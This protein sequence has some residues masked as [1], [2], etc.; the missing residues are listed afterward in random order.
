MCDCG[1][2]AGNI[3]SLL[4]TIGTF[5]L[6]AF[7][8]VQSKQTKAQIG[9]SNRQASSG[10]ISATAAIESA[11]TAVDVHS[12][13]IRA[14]I[15]Q[16]AP[17]V[18]AFF[19]RP[20]GPLVD[21]QRSGMPQ[22]N[23]LRLLD[24]ESI[25]RS[26]SKIGQQYAFPADR[27]T[28]IWYRGVGAVVNEGSTSA[29]VR[30]TGESKFIEGTSPLDG[31]ALSMPYVAG[32]GIVAEAILPPGSS[33]LF[34]WAAGHSAQ[35]WVSAV[36]NPEPPSP[37]GAIWQTIV[38]FDA[39]RA[40]IVDTIEAVYTP[41]PLAESPGRQGL[42]QLQPEGELSR[43]YVQPVTRAYV[44]EGDAIAKRTRQQEHYKE[45]TEAEQRG[46]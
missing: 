9:A 17:R 25:A 11:R 16:T 13:A 27:G 34:E 2:N 45:F 3:V 5:A 14:R 23:D 8:F 32:E 39:Q 29:Y 44:V 26:A 10:E 41:T 43:V 35:G 38:V 46:K 7:A 19:E 31:R 12:E 24:S 30:L 33:A 42:W 37:Y 40:A 6:A 21:N 28:F 18:V 36:E 4:T 1:W 15:D 22:A 20:E